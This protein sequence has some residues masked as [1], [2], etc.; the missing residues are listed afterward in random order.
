MSKRSQVLGLSWG[1][2]CRVCGWRWWRTLVERFVVFD[3]AGEPLRRRNGTTSRHR[4][5]HPMRLTAYDGW[6]C[7]R[8]IGRLGLEVSRFDADHSVLLP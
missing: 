7:R 2:P 1:I 3:R 5:R 6:C 8:C 4:A